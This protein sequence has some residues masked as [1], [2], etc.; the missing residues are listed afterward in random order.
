MISEMILELDLLDHLNCQCMYV[1]V[2]VYI[3]TTY[4]R[5]GNFHR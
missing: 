2:H 1:H 5:S 4:H 3:L